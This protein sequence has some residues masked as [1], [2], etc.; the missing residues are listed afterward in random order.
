MATTGGTVLEGGGCPIARQWWQRRWRTA[1][2]VIAT[3]TGWWRGSLLAPPFDTDASAWGNTTEN[4]WRFCEEPPPFWYQGIFSFYPALA[5]CSTMP[6]LPL[7]FL[8]PLDIK[9]DR[10]PSTVPW[11]CYCQEQFIFWGERSWQHTIDQI[12]FCYIT[13]ICSFD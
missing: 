11:G 10:F 3:T 6:K 1:T 5:M 13:N 7:Q 9:K 12:C 2:D 8:A 4:A